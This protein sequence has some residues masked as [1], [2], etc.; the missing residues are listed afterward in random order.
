MRI[1]SFKNFRRL[2]ESIA[3]VCVLG[4]GVM[5][6]VPASAGDGASSYHSEGSDSS[7]QQRFI[8]FSGFDISK[9]AYSYYGGTLVALNGDFSR[10][11]FVFRALGVSSDYEY[12]SGFPIGEVDADERLF[13][14]MI[15]YQR[16]LGVVTATA[17]V[18][19]EYRDIDLSPSDPGSETQGSESGFK[20]AL[21]AETSDE[22]PLFLSFS[23]SYST[24]FDSSYAMLR[25]GYNMKWLVVGAEGSY[26]EIDSDD[27]KRLGGFVTHRFN[28]KPSMPAQ[29]TVNAGYQFVD[30]ESGE[31]TSGGG[32]GYYGGL[33]FSFSF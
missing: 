17:Y 29:V 31:F 25:V 22:I 10:D 28:I 21:D 7:G 26:S 24:A 27:S 6:A 18:G 15:G 9:D 4:L 3:L 16:T 30:D 1:T 13:D 8:S 2:P 12:S 23:G 20:V 5:S 32:E 11:G 14:V 19:F 33:S